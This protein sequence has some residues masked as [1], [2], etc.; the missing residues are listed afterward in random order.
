MCAVLVDIEDEHGKLVLPGH[1]VL[2]FQASKKSVFL[3]QVVSGRLEL[4]IYSK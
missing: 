4:Q 1:E 3:L 2:L